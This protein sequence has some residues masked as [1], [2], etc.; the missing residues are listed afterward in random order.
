M[1]KI[2]RGLKY[3]TDTAKEVGEWD[4]GFP[5]NDFNYEE[6][7]LYKKR[8]GQFFIHGWGGPKTKYAVATGLNCWTGG[9]KITPVSYDEAREWAEEKLDAEEY[10]SIFGTVQESGERAVTAISISALAMEKLRTMAAKEK[11]TMS[12][13]IEEMILERGK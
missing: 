2:I 9:E 10:E 4:N 5:V 1:K 3:D 6:E 13:L 11:K 12:G 8:S 7:H